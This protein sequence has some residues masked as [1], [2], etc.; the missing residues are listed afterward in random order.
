MNQRLLIT[1]TLLAGACAVA[2][3]CKSKASGAKGAGGTATPGTGSAPPVAPPAASPDAAPAPP[4]P[5]PA[6]IT[7]TAGQEPPRGCFAWAAKAHAAACVVGEVT[8][9]E[10]ALK[11]A[12][13]GGTGEELALGATLDEATATKLTAALATDGYAAPTGAATALEVDKPM[14]SGAATLTLT[15]KT[16]AKG[17]DNVAPTAAIKLTAVCNG[18]G[19]RALRPGA[20][21][22]DARRHGP[23]AGRSA[24]DRGVDQ[25]RARRRAERDARRRGARPGHLRRRRRQPVDVRR[26]PSARGLSRVAGGGSIPA[27]PGSRGARRRAPC[28]SAHA[29][30]SRRRRP[31]RAA[32]RARRCAAA[33]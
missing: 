32:S 33:A 12:F 30:R 29:A 18:K 23:R 14:T 25:G 26:R 19:R 20:R 17:G 27:W 28:N 2:S 9:G 31:A 5:A 21:G 15:S 10:A 4:P 7:V 16:T 24:A 13:V 22:R 11:V 3:G 1:A 8:N 6:A